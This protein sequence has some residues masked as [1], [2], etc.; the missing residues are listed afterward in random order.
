VGAYHGLDQLRYNIC[1][2]LQNRLCLT[3]KE[4]IMEN[5][6]DLLK[7]LNN[8]LRKWW[9]ILSLAVLAGLVGLGISYLLPP[10]YQA[11]A[12]F[13][14]SIDFT[15]INF[16]NLVDSD[17]KTYEFTQY[18]EDLAVQVVQRML[19]EKMD[20]AYNF[21]LTLDSGLDRTR[22]KRDS[23]IQRYHAQWYLR[24]RHEDPAVAQSI[25]NY[26]AEEGEKALQDAQD[27][28]EA[29]A[30]VIVDLVSKACLPETPQYRHR[31]TLVLAG[32]V[33]GLLIGIILVDSRNRFLA[34][35]TSEV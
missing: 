30:F 6:F 13:H 35:S 21:A 10:M 4:T 3:W 23:Q 27:S 16:E 20:A 33:I 9:L 34:F 7:T 11:E 24:Y 15:E 29:E 25:V 22:F 32:T 17:D 2:V 12:V 31:N 19:F 14:A 1:S 18:D 5:D 8:L 26:W 28:G